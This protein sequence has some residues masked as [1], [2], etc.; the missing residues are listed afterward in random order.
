MGAKEY[1]SRQDMKIL[2]YSK[3]DWRNGKKQKNT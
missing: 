2:I 1:Q 3:Y